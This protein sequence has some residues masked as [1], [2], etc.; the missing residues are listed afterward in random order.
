VRF[1]LDVVFFFAGV[2]FF[3]ADDLPC[4]ATVDFFVTGAFAIGTPSPSP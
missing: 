2:D 3:A 4:D 1:L